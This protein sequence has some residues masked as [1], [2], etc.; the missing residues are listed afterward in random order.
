MVDCVNALKQWMVKAIQA[1]KPPAPVKEEETFANYVKALKEWTGKS[2]ATIIFDSTVDEFTDD[3]LF[4]K[5]KGRP[6]IALVGFTT[7][8][9]VFG[10]FYSVAMT[11]Q[12]KEF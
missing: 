11:E 10:G 5:I 12:D 3:G 6:N 4:N 7:E 8:G 2:S 1:L 9:D